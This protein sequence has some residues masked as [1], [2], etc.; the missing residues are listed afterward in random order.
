[1]TKG[2]ASNTRDMN[3]GDELD[4]GDR[5]VIVVENSPDG[6][7]VIW[8]TPEG[9]GPNYG[10]LPHAAIYR[11][12]YEREDLCKRSYWETHPDF[13]GKTGEV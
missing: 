4:C 2:M 6:L 13:T 8:Y 9:M 7:G 10:V 11:Q 3:I 1:M 12:M 5:R